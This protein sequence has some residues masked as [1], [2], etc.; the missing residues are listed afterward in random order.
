MACS[1]NTYQI[2]FKKGASKT[3]LL[4]V[5]DEDNDRVDLSGARVKM[6][7]VDLAS[8]VQFTR[9]SQIGATEVEILTQAGDTLGQA[10]IYIV[11][12]NTSGLTTGQYRYDIWV[13][14]ASGER[15]PVVCPSDF[16]IQET[17]TTF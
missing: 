8:A 12:S 3:Y 7:V 14:L 1:D 5:T 15:H 9:D 2:L 6:T 16:Y 4:T 13:E 11:P 17:Y 10:K